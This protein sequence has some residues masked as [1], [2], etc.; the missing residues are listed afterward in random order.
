M[1]HEYGHTV[2]AEKLC[3]PVFYC[4]IFL[5]SPLYLL[6]TMIGRKNG[7]LSRNYYNMPWERSADML[8]GLDP[9]TERSRAGRYAEWSDRISERYMRFHEFISH[10]LTLKF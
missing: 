10:L 5:H 4:S 9:R 6:L 3:P 7:W 2:Q 1:R 8:G